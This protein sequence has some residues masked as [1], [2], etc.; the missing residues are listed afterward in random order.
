MV[1]LSLVQRPQTD[2]FERRQPDGA[3]YTREA[4]LRVIF[5]Q[6][7]QFQH[8]QEIFYYT[9]DPE[10][11][12][13]GTVIG[14][15]G[16]EVTVNENESPDDNL[17]P[18]ERRTWRGALVL[19]DPAHHDDGQKAA[20]EH[21]STVGKPVSVFESL[22]ARINAGGGEP[23]VLEANAIVPSEAFWDF[24]RQNEGEITS[25]QFE[26]VAPNMFGE[27]DDYDREMRDMQRHE[28]AQ[29]AKL[30]IE[31]KDGLNLN[32][33]RIEQAADYTIKGAGSITART[34]KGRGYNSKD[35]AKRIAIPNK[36]I[37][38]SSTSGLIA[39]IVKRVFGS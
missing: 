8:R 31:S 32:T 38:S 30:K 13:S 12:E 15:I 3:L 4:W 1:R 22:A 2:V 7:I 10:Q 24:V 39:Q 17:A 28:K 20:I 19:I 6:K 18:K 11:A 21:L 16:R 5:G 23:F 33:K 9:P 34:K 27:A 14:R 26:F 36:D 35:K 37:D 29:K 25:V